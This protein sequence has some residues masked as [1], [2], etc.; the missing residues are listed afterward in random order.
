VESDPIGLKGGLNTF[1]YVGDRPMAYFDPYG[2]AAL[3]LPEMRDL[4]HANNH[5]GLSDELV[6]CLMW[7]ES[8]FRPKA[9]GGKPNIGNG[10][11]GATRA[12]T[13]QVNINFGYTVYM[14][15]NGWSDP[16]W[17]VD[18]ATRYLQ[19]VFN[20]PGSRDVARSLRRYGTNKPSYPAEKII[21]CEKCMQ[22]DHSGD[23]ACRS[24]EGCLKIVHD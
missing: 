2:L 16:S 4:V 23:T 15:E 19:W 12:A 13:D 8:N 18:V 14:Y 24:P 3:G 7:N 21:L 9:G 1:A 17:N 11:G 20:H 6:I 22:G 10:L 5:S